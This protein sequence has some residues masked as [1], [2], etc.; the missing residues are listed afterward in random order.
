M[1]HP[2]KAD[3]VVITTSGQY[4]LVAFKKDGNILGG[5]PLTPSETIV[6]VT[7]LMSA[8]RAALDGKVPQ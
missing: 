6:L 2:L 1:S 3:K 7:E 5:I 4:V 8:A